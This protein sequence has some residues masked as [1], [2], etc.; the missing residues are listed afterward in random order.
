MFI[1][2]IS[3]SLFWGIL[4]Y[5]TRKSGQHIKIANFVKSKMPDDHLIKRKFKKYRKIVNPFSKIDENNST[6]E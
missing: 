6:E 2:L 3:V 4:A 5:Y 1:E